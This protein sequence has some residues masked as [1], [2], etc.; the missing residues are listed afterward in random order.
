MAVVQDLTVEDF[1]GLGHHVIGRIV[2]DTGVV[3][4]LS[5][6][7][8]LSWTWVINLRNLHLI[9]CIDLFGII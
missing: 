1:H 3:L 6:V 4:G 2:I 7:L 5:L 8:I 9:D